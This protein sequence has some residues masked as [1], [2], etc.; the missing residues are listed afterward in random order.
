MR[1]KRL[2]PILYAVT[3]MLVVTLA[4]SGL[5]STPGASNFFMATDEEGTNRTNAFSPSDD[6]Y[7][8]FNISGVEAGT[9][10]Q[11]RWYGL[12]LPD[13]DPNEPLQTID[14]PYEEGV[15]KVY[16]QLTSAEPWPV[17]NYKVEIYMDGSKVGE[18][19]FSVQ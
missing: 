14:Y 19:T 2:Y 17:G 13:I 12:D 6:F 9:A 7:V 11:S 1:N 10:F 5:S 15:T 16:F 3:V 18:Q 4:C 8:F